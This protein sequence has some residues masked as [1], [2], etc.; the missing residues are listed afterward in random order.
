MHACMLLF[1][2]SGMGYSTSETVSMEPN[3][4]L[5]GTYGTGPITTHEQEVIWKIMKFNIQTVANVHPKS[6]PPTAER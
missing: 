3:G 4:T 5:I 6:R 2:S 1:A